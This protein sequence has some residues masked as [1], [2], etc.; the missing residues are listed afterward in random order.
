MLLYCYYFLII[1][2]PQLTLTL[3]VEFTTTSVVINGIFSDSSPQNVHTF[4]IIVNNMTYTLGLDSFPLS[5]NISSFTPGL[6]YTITAIAENI[7]GNS[8]VAT[9]TFV[10]P[11]N[12]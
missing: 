1:V 7:I 5:I 6:S 9:T 3:N 2:L 12:I 8:T 11:S 4:Y 10:I